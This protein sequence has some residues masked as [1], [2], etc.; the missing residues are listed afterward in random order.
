MYGPELKAEGDEE[1]TQLHVKGELYHL[2][3]F[4]VFL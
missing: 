4:A 1:E 2:R 3:P